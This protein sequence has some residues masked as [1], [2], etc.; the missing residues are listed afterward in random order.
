M[1]PHD[2]VAFPRPSWAE[3]SQQAD[4]EVQLSQAGR[5]AMILTRLWGSRS[6]VAQDL[7]ELNGFL[8]EFKPS[9]SSDIEACGSGDGVRLTPADG[10]LTAA[11]AT[12]TLPSMK[13]GEIRDH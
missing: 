11:A 3:A 1:L 8:R 10:Y 6:A 12:R 7:L 4:T 13:F 9:G 2:L 5:R